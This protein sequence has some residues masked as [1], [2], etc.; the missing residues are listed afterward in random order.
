MIWQILRLIAVVA[1]L[2]AAAA[3]STPRG[4][5]PLALRGLWRTL[6]R[7]P[8]DAEGERVSV[9]RRLL[10]FVLLLAAA[11]LALLPGEG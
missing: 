1:L 11:A 7:S 4:R 9:R 10:A 2:C 6:G 8:A 3:I 5:I